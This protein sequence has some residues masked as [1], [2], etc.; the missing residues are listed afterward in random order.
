MVP[1]VFLDLEAAQ[2]L[3]EAYAGVTDWKNFRGEP[4]PKFD[5]LPDV[6]KA[7]WAAANDQA[8]ARLLPPEAISD[9]EWSQIKF[10]LKYSDGFQDAGIPGHALLLV[11]AKLARS[12]KLTWVEGLKPAP[13]HS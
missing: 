7:A 8:V 10:A 13:A 11:I 5:A 12:L 3:Y 1:T 4:M 2:A 9:R 6:I